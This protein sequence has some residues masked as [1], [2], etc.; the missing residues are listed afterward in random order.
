[1]QQF[2]PFP[3]GTCRLEDITRAHWKNYFLLTLR[4]SQE[5]ENG[6]IKRNNPTSLEKSAA[7]LLCWR[8]TWGLFTLVTFYRNGCRHPR[9]TS[10]RCSLPPGWALRSTLLAKINLTFSIQSRASPEPAPG[11]RLLSNPR[12][13]TAVLSLS[14]LKTPH[15]KKINK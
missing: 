6:T 10:S 7:S 3:W 8:G 2:W 5:V 9:A 1:M 14:D 11:Q 13:N 4:R 15:L 12:Q